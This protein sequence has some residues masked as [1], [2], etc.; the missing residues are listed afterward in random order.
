MR[1]HWAYYPTPRPMRLPGPR[2]PRY[3]GK[4]PPTA[5]SSPITPL[6][7]HPSLQEIAAL[8]DHERQQLVAVWASIPPADRERR[9]S[10]DAWTAAEVLDHLRLVE[11]GSARLLARRLERARAAGL[12]AETST[13]SRVGG[14]AMFDI[15]AGATRL[16]APEAMRP[17]T[18]VSAAAAEQGL[19]ETRA[20]VRALLAAADG[21]AL[22]DVRAMHLRFGDLDLYQWLEF[23]ALHERRHARQLARVRDA[24]AAGPAPGPTAERPA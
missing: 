15:A 12:G 22:G 21:L 13:T 18:D 14:L 19:E 11:G 24:L 23:I 2:A 5:D 16:D 6:R 3:P 8:L 10:P 7:M 1:G 9:P 20:A 4:G 17:T